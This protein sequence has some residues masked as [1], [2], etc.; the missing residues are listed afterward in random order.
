M[1]A[2]AK[3]FSRITP[4]ISASQD[5]LKTVAL[6]SATGLLVT[7]LMAIYGLDFGVF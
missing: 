3:A 1:A 7:L 4:V 2:I 6:F 5:N